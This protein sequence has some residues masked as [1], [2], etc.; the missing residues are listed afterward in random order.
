MFLCFF[1]LF[2]STNVRLLFV[3]CAK[4]GQIDEKNL[5]AEKAQVGQCRPT[6]IVRK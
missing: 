3:I 6:I 2:P 1:K 5:P 4:Q